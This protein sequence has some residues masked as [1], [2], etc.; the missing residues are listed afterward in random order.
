ME[1]L[2]PIQSSVSASTD[3]HNTFD[4]DSSLI[5]KFLLTSTKD[6]SEGNSKDQNDQL[7]SAKAPEHPRKEDRRRS[8]VLPED[9]AITKSTTVDQESH[10]VLVVDDEKMCHTIVSRMLKK[11]G[12][13]TLYA[14]N[15][16]EALR[17]LQETAPRLSFIIMDCQV[18][19]NTI[20]FFCT[21]LSCIY[22]PRLL[23]LFSCLSGR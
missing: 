16:K 9:E 17:L 7:P 14:E 11:K 4:D 21:T 18:S 6:E 22:V 3:K 15:G 20:S 13:S 19:T 23:F 10:A 8:N 12:Y 1:T 5:A 2:T